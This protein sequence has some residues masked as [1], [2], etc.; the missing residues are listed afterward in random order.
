MNS[1]LVRSVSISLLLAGAASAQE[2]APGPPLP[3]K[4]PTPLKLQVVFARYQGEKRVS[5]IPYTLSL[6][7]DDRPARVRMGIQVPIQTQA[8]EGPP[9]V[10]YRDVGNNLDCGAEAQDEGRFKV[11]CSFEQSS[12]YS[13]GDTLAQASAIGQVS[14]GSLP[15]FRTFRSEANLLLRDGQTAQYTAATDPVSGEVLKIEVGLFLV[16]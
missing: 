4:A 9:Q 8:K 13:A 11:S 6:N 2:R 12:L 10:S 16:K 14:L 3:R 15:L 7:S 5:N 1:T